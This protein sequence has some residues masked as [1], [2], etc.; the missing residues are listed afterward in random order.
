MR[1]A[2]VHVETVRFGRMVGVAEV[3]LADERGEIAGAAQLRRQ[4][5]LRGREVMARLRLEQAAARVLLERTL[6]PDRDPHPRRVTAGEQHRPR[7][8]TD[9]HRVGLGEAKALAGKGV[10]PRRLVQIGAITTQVGPA[11]VISEDEDNVGRRG[12]RRVG[13]RKGVGS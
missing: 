7:G 12:R 13:R 2:D 10:D 1:A 5:R 9:R 6:A 11:E 3:P 4:R 8:R